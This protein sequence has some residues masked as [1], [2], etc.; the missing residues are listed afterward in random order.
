MEHRSG[1]PRGQATARLLP[2]RRG[3]AGARVAMRALPL[4]TAIVVAVSGGLAGV[5]AEGPP[6]GAHRGGDH[7]GGAEHGHPG[8][9]REH[10]GGAAPVRVVPHP[11]GGQGQLP[12]GAP[13]P[14]QLALP[15]TGAASGGG[16]QGTPGNPGTQPAGNAPAPPAFAPAAPVVTTLP[17]PNDV[18]LPLP[19]QA[20][21]APPTQYPPTVL[22]PPL[23]LPAPTIINVVNGGSS[24][25]PVVVLFLCM[26]LLLGAL[27]VRIGRRRA[28]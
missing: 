10:E 8:D 21:P 27:A 26:L 22:I 3:H 12:A 4:L 9:S 14:P 2:A 23:S 1:L 16:T 28:H 19:P 11:G 6:P 15:G 20:T 7:G 18:V 5:S 13:S 25:A 17:P 24:I